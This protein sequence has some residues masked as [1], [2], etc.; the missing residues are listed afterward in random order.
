MSAGKSIAQNLAAWTGSPVGVS[1][2]SLNITKG[3]VVVDTS[4]PNIYLRTS[5]S[6]NSAFSQVAFSNGGT[7][8]GPVIA[9]GLT[10]S[11]SVANDFSG[12]TGTFLTSTGL[13]T[14]SGGLKSGTPQA[15]AAAG[16]VNLTTLTTT[17][18]SVGAIALTLADGTNGQIKTIVMLVDGGDATLTPT[19]KTGFSTV[20]FN[21]VGDGVILQFFTTQGWI[22]IANNGATLA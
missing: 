16:A 14:I 9:G 8:T 1:T 22:C 5:T 17:I 4:T 21:D 6:D 11:G 2:N 10:A 12:S 19:T 3:T 13:T 7:L 18:S 20:T 15:L